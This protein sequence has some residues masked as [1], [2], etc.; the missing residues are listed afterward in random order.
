MINLWKWAANLCSCRFST[1]NNKISKFESTNP[2]RSPASSKINFILI[3][4]ILILTSSFKAFP[5]FFPIIEQPSLTMQFLP[6]VSV[7]ASVANR[8]KS[9]CRNL[10]YHST[11]LLTGPESRNEHQLENG[12]TMKKNCLMRQLKNLV[13]KVNI[14]SEI[15]QDSQFLIGCMQI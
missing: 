3:L 6:D 10:I 7:P 5:P 14:I 8:P 4:L 11:W 15:L 1:Q 12:L 9:V 13:L 2:I